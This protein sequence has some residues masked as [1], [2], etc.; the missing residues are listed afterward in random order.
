MLSVRCLPHLLS[1][2]LN[3][4]KVAEAPFNDLELADMTRILESSDEAHFYRVFK[5]ILTLASPIF[6]ARFSALPPPHQKF[7]DVRILRLVPFPDPSTIFDLALRH[8]YPVRTPKT[9][10]FHNASVLAEFVRKYKVAR[11]ALD[12][13]IAG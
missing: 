6:A 4:R 11:E 5:K 12:N 10:T 9:D 3:S 8:I 1:Q 2:S 13:F 7:H